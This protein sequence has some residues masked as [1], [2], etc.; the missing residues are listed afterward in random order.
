MQTGLETIPT[1]DSAIDFLVFDWGILFTATAVATLVSRFDLFTTAVGFLYPDSDAAT[2]QISAR[3]AEVGVW[4]FVPLAVSARVDLEALFSAGIGALFIAYL[5]R[6]P[7]KGK[8]SEVVIAA[9]IAA[10]DRLVPDVRIRIPGHDVEGVIEGIDT[11]ETHVRLDN[12]DL[13]HVP[14]DAIVGER[15]TTVAT[16]K[17][18]Q[19]SPR[20]PEPE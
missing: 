18:A 20:G 5:V 12:G 11:D 6:E 13:T 4:L 16:A 15:W 9:K 8:L 3:L 14:N 19:L 10:N 2:R 17:D 1:F 7:L